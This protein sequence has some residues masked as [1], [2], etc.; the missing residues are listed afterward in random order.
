MVSSLPQYA[1]HR[2]P[3]DF[4]RLGDVDRPHALRFQFA[5]P[6]RLYRR[7]PALVDARGPP[8]LRIGFQQWMAPGE[9][10]PAAMESPFIAIDLGEARNA[11]K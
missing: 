4:E 6:W 2:R 11:T 9:P 8:E 1:V 10:P 5:H 3:T 7:G